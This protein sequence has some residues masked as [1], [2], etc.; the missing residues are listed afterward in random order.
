VIVVTD[1]SVILNLCL[2]R[3][4][5]LLISLFGAV[6]APTRVVAEFQRL[7]ATDSRF[8]GL[9]FPDFIHQAAPVVVVKNLPNFSRLHG[10]ETAALSLAVER[11]ADAVL[12]DERAGRAA[13]NALGLKT[14]GLLGILLLARQKGLI[15]AIA[16]L[17]DRLQNEAR[18]WI[19][20]SLRET[21]IKA[22]GELP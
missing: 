13:A 17:L 22:A 19:D 21:I 14:V 6:L 16:P 5:S 20:L 2:L 10:G 8:Q 9:L 15:P 18:F 12:M 3:Q 11:G 7:A 4:E 1:T